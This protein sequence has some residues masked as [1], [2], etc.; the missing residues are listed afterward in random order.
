M[1]TDNARLAREYADAATQVLGGLKRGSYDAA[2]ALALT[3]I[4]HSLS[5]LAQAATKE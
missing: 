5:V 3:S 4:A 2:Q 1:T